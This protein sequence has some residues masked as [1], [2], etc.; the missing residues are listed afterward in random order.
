MPFSD[1]R[2][3]CLFYTDEG[4]GDPV[5]FV[6]GFSCDSH[7]WSWQLP[8]FV[9]AGYR[10]I[11]ADLRGHGRSSVPADGFTPLDFADDLVTLLDRLNVGPVIAIGHSLG[12][13]I[14][15]TLA[16]EHPEKVK[17]LVC[18]DPGYLLPESFRPMIDTVLETLRDGDP[19]AT[20]QSFLG[21]SYS[22]ASPAYLRTWHMRRIAGVPHHVLHGALAGLFDGPEAIGFD[23]ISIPYLRQRACPVLA[24]YVDPTR[25]TLEAGLMAHDRSKVVTCEGS[26][27]WLHQE[28]SG[29]VNHVIAD[30]LTSLQG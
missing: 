25:A 16:V 6:H 8:D 18:I 19:V 3:V 2:D 5:L 27:H 17:A 9:A 21:A 10:A 15:S 30:W 12:A 14:V 4:E 11:A 1:V 24:F 28:R 7:D 26:G 20:A 13:A 22:A 23:T 29:E